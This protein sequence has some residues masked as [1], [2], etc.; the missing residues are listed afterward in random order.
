MESTF[1]T[2]SGVLI[3]CGISAVTFVVYQMRNPEL[4]QTLKPK[5]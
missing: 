4:N 2:A 5:N 3:L 1:L